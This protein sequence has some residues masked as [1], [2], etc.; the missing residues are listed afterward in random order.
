[1]RKRA[2]DGPDRVPLHVLS[3]VFLLSESP[4][5]P[6]NFVGST[7]LRE[8]LDVATLDAAL[9]GACEALPHFGWVIEAGLARARWRPGRRPRARAGFADIGRRFRLDREPPLRVRVEGAQVVWEVHHSLTDGLGLILFAEQTLARAFGLEPRRLPRLAVDDPLR[10]L[11][12]GPPAPRPAP[13]RAVRYGELPRLLGPRRRTPL[14]VVL[15][16][17]RAREVAGRLVVGAGPGDLVVAGYARALGA[18]RASRGRGAARREPLRVNLMLPL[19]VRELFSVFS[20]FN[21]CG[22]VLAPLD[23]TSTT[24]VAELLAATLA[25]RALQATADHQRGALAPFARLF[26]GPVAGAIPF[27]GKRALAAAFGALLTERIQTEIV[28]FGGTR[29]FPGPL[30]ERIARVTAHPAVKHTRNAALGVIGHG[31]ELCVVLH[32]TRPDPALANAFAAEMRALDPDL[33][34]AGPERLLS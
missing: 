20:A 23:V 15:D 21:C 25:A 26:A 27:A 33:V 10:R 34:R 4:A 24:S 32:Q 13:P 14:L 17:A 3:W 12:D 9:A 18:W 31:D 30:G 29:P 16:L 5:T 8:P 7:T 2:A 1:M 28:T 22:S 6:Y 11:A 19:N